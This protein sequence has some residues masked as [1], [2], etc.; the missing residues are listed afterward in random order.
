MSIHNLS[1]I[2]GP[3]LLQPAAKN[4][5]TSMAEMM[6]VGAEQCMKQSAIVYYFLSLLVKGKSLRRSSA[7]D[8]STNL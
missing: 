7:G 4:A 1:T 5:A 2:F 6:T 8:A 3:T